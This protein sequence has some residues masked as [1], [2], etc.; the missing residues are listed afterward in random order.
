MAGLKVYAL[1]F[2]AHI[3]G[4]TSIMAPNISYSREELLQ[5]QHDKT[6]M[7]IETY[8]QM[9]T[10][11]RSP[12]KRGCRSGGVRYH[13][14]TTILDN[15]SIK[16]K[17]KL[18]VWNAQSVGNKTDKLCDYVSD[19]DIDVLCLTETWLKSEDS[20]IIGDL[21]PPGYS[22]INVPREHA[23]HGGIGVLFKS[24]IHLGLLKTNV[25]FP[26]YKTFEYASVS[27]T[28]RTL[29]LVVVYRTPPST[30][31]KLRVSEYLENFHEFVG[32]VDQLSGKIL[33]VG[34][35]NVHYDTPE[36]SHVRHFSTTLASSGLVQHIV[37][38]THRCRH[39]L[40]LV[41]TRQDEPLVKRYTID[42]ENFRKDHFMINCVVDIP[43]P[44]AEKVTYTMRKFQLIDQQ[45][46]SD[47][48][49]QR[50]HDIKCRD[51]DNV[52]TL[53]ADYNHPAWYDESVADARR[54]RRRCERRWRKSRTDANYEKYMRSKQTVSDV[55]CSTKKQ[56]YENKLNNCS[57]KDMFKTV[58]EL[59]HRSNKTLPDTNSPLDLEGNSLLGK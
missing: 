45:A 28:S 30:T 53:L 1:C 58:N 51:Y 54:E 31:N 35:F 13:N 57:V 26:K 50:M 44:S 10:S 16:N 48:P 12:T 20:G 3:L 18:S 41:I 6:S 7:P 22:F 46:L 40:D 43:K 27:N 52:N 23:E 59:L 32:I 21:S 29:T 4:L 56:Y 25:Q 19:N 24:Q 11:S 42:R 55:I 38:P 36:K 47:D 33:L 14:T 39:T 37:G 2:T 8:R 17:L 49:A 5:L 15:S 34:D 9:G